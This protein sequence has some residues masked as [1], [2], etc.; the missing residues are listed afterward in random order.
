MCGSC[1]KKFYNNIIIYKEYENTDDRPIIIST[2][3]I[4]MHI[5][6]LLLYFV[7]VYS[8]SSVTNRPL[9]YR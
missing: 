7:K 3:I 4:G 6:L 2:V 8:I 1:R 9:Y 5:Y